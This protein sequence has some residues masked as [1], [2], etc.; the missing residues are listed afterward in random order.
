MIIWKQALPYVWL[1]GILLLTFGVYMPVM[2]YAWINGTDHVFII[3]NSL[4]HSLSM[5][6]V[7]NIFLSTVNGSYQPLTFL[8]YAVEFSLSSDPY[9]TIH[10]VNLLL[11]LLNIILFFRLLQMMS[12]KLYIALIATLLF[13]I[14]PMNAE[15]VSWMSSRGQLLCA[16]FLLSGL[17][18]YLQYLRVEVRKKRY[19]RL[20]MLWFIFALLS[21]PMAIAFPFLLMLLDFLQNRKLMESLQEKFPMFMLSLLFLLI[22]VL[23][24]NLAE[25]HLTSG[26]GIFH[27]LMYGLYAIALWMV[28]FIVPY[29][30]AAY[31]PYPSGFS[32][33]IIIFI[34][35]LTA[36]LVSVFLFLRKNRLLISGFLFYLIT[37]VTALLFSPP[38][39][40]ILQEHDAYIPY[41]GLFFLTGA[42]FYYLLNLEMLKRKIFAALIIS[43][44]SVYALLLIYLTYE[45]VGV[46]A[47]SDSLWSEVIETYPDDHYAYFM[48][49]DYWAMTGQYEKAMFDYN[50]C[51]RRNKNAYEA[52]NN[53][54]LIY[55]EEKETRLALAG[56][57]RAIEINDHFYKSFLNR[58]I[59]YMR[60]GKNNAAMEDMDRA[61]E[62]NPDEPLVYYNRGLLFERLNLL[63]DA[64][65]EFSKAISMDPYRSIFYKD[66]GKAYVW[67]NEFYFAEL[68][69]SKAIDL[70]PYNADIWFRRSL[71]R[72]SQ[73]KFEEGLEDAF[74]ARKLGFPVEEEYIRGLTAEIL[75]DEL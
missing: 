7:L 70:D 46:W 3:E 38:E 50:Q 74:M 55:L 73:E 39:A 44:F 31:H 13:A 67:M 2:Q 65:N 21:N 19:I 36:L 64:I 10:L 5:N 48:R 37:I 29:G 17:L 45:R 58:G 15:T 26:P 51:I 12:R 63:Q 22:S 62:L 34:V 47:S 1:F 9:R 40:S 56:F 66:R 54:G 20:S 30:L 32:P 28:K 18:S 41:M 42:L 68:D 43:V 27:S 24:M 16:F 59:A 33:L 57:N 49:G 71:A 60:I 4:V 14:H 69:F 72:V 25:T 61:V 35:F 52:I 75:K 8:S 23:S 53:L 11:H 6:S